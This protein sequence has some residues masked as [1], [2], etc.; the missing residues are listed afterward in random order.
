MSTP[1]RRFLLGLA[2]ILAVLATSVLA[3]LAGVYW[4]SLPERRLIYHLHHH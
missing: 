3:A 4:S 1:S 2:L